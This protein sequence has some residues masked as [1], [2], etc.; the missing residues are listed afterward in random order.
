MVTIEG[1]LENTTDDLKE[2][3]YVTFDLYDKEG[4]S[5]G[6]AEAFT[7]RLHAGKKWRFEA[8]GV[9]EAELGEIELYDLGTLY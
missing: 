4:F 7:E 6:Q 5:L 2:F 8:I 9:T 3:V 1:V